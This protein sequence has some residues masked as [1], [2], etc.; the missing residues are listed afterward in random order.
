MLI[1]VFDFLLVLHALLLIV[2][3]D[4][5]QLSQ[6]FLD[7]RIFLL[8]YLKQLAVVVILVFKLLLYFLLLIV[9]SSLE[10]IVQV[11]QLFSFYFKVFSFP[12]ELSSGLFNLLLVLFHRLSELCLSLLHFHFEFATLL[13]LHLHV[14]FESYPCS[15]VILALSLQSM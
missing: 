14:I 12:L 5:L 6:Q 4:A 15:S 9:N 1:D 2:V 13:V 11:P 3:F 7:L 10:S 8:H